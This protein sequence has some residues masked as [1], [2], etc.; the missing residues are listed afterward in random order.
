MKKFLL[1][2]LIFAIPFYGVVAYYCLIFNHKEI[3]GDFG[4][5]AEIPFGKAYDQFLAK[6]YLPECYTI[7]YNKSKKEYP[8]CS[9]GDS[10][11]A[12]GITGFQNYV[13]HLQNDSILLLSGGLPQAVGLLNTGFFKEHNT[14]W[15]VLEA[16]ERYWIRYLSTLDFDRKMQ[17]EE[18]IIDENI[19]VEINQ[20]NKITLSRIFRWV[21]NRLGIRTPVRKATLRI[22]AFS[23]ETMSKELYF[24]QEDLLMDS[25]Q[26][27]ELAKSN[28]IK[29]ND[30]FTKQDITFVFVMAADKYDVYSS[31]IENNPYPE[32]HVLDYFK[33]LSDEVWFINTKELLLPHIQAG[34]KD[35]YKINDSHWSYIG[36][37]LV[38]EEIIKR[39]QNMQQR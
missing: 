16:V 17:I 25:P 35:V 27:I 30:I 28:L 10:F 12:G 39:Y 34:C 8:Y 21:T 37:Q 36:H 5:I 15:V 38:A 11:S 14:K 19:P 29:L 24:Y 2:S 18:K 23:H 20:K 22:D 26:A 31:F 4:A 6:N 7:A 3:S 13:G 32:N 33:D 9:A 1:L